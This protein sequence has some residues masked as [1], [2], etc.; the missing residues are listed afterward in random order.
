M[1]NT[2]PAFEPLSEP[3]SQTD[4]TSS[5]SC[6]FLEKRAALTV[7]WGQTATNR[8]CIFRVCAPALHSWEPTLVCLSHTCQRWS[9]FQAYERDVLEKKSIFGLRYRTKRNMSLDGE[10][11]NILRQSYPVVCNCS[12]GRRLCRVLLEAARPKPGQILSFCVSSDI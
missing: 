2:S 8:S 11:W 12:S 10:P 4:A 6:T 9:F 3:L 7:R 5:T 1:S